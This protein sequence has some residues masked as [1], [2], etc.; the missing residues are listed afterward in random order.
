MYGPEST[1]IIIFK[2]FDITGVITKYLDFENEE[3]IRWKS[4]KKSL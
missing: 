1:S 3:E 2:A 4:G